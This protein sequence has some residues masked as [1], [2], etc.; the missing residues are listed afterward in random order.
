MLFDYAVNVTK[1]SG[2]ESKLLKFIFKK[3]VQSYGYHIQC[4]G[5]Y[6]FIGS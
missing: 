5:N 6:Y 1:F 4:N 2:G 3:Q